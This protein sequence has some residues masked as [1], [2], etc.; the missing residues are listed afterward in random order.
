MG[1]ISVQ[2]SDINSPDFE[3]HSKFEPFVIQTEFNHFKSGLA[4]DLDPNHT[5]RIQSPIKIQYSDLSGNLPSSQMVI[6]LGIG[7]V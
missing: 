3:K 4:Q 1:S 2:K 5:H 7:Q 6:L